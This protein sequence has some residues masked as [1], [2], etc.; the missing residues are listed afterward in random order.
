MVPTKC[1]RFDGRADLKDPFFPANFESIFG[2]SYNLGYLDHDGASSDFREGTF[3]TSIGIERSCH[4]R[5]HVIKGIDPICAHN[6][7]I[8]R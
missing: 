7:W 4:P 3:I 6:D 2:C 5:G 8:D 1:S